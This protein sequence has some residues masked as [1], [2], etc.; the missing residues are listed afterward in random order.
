MSIIAE[1]TKMRLTP[2]DPDIETL[3]RRITEKQLDLQT[4]FQR[5]EVWGKSKQQKLIDTILRKWYVPPIHVIKHEG[6]SVLEVLDGKQR[7]TAIH[8]F[9]NNEFTVDGAVEPNSPFIAEL[10]GNR[11][12]NLP[13]HIREE[14][15]QFPIR[16]F[17]ID[18]FTADEPGELFFR[19]NSPTYLTAA[20]QRNAFYGEPRQQIKK[21]VA[22]MEEIG[23]DKYYIGF[24]NSRMAYDDVFARVCYVFEIQTLHKRI[25][26][27]E[28][29]D[30]YRDPTP[31]PPDLVQQLEGAIIEFRES[32]QLAQMKFRF[33]KATLFSWFVFLL[34]ANRNFGININA[35]L[36]A[37][38]LS[39]LAQLRENRISEEQ[40]IS[41]NNLKEDFL[42]ELFSVFED[43]S[44][45][46]V[47][48]VDSVLIR[49]I[50]LWITLLMVA[51]GQ[52]LKIN[53]QLRE[54][55]NE[56]QLHMKKDGISRI[57][58]EKFF[59]QIMESNFWGNH[60]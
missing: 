33:N 17:T 8:A 18:N 27:K 37:G 40:P 32:Q 23:V 53:D 34:E 30:R 58:A 9:M 21:I 43:R 39:Q 42:G 41:S 45:A 11:Y 59:Y 3:Y 16:L 24:S 4:D 38:M 56:F 20:E 6:S 15:K 31:F 44:R 29:S 25:T 22:V 1:E 7:L 36:Q 13:P 55:E 49:D 10:H 5:G 51:Q 26:S 14:F 2:S 28:L 48:N 52:G 60:I 54:L 19:L 12:N 57:H 47:G 50:M 35:K 46:R